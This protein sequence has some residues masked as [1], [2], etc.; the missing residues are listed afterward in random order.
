MKATPFEHDIVPEMVPLADVWF[1]TDVLNPV[2]LA[3]TVTEYP[4]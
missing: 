3:V 4:A 1:V 2:Q